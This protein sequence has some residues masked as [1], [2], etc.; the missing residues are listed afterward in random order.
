MAQKE[1]TVGEVYTGKSGAQ[2]KV[3]AIEGGFVTATIAKVGQGKGNH[4][5]VG[6]VSK[7]ITSV[8]KAW[9]KI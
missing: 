6:T 5:P 7:T 9:A 2:K 8:F 3:T 1:I 4:K